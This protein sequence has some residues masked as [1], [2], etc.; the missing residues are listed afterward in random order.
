MTKTNMQKVRK[1]QTL[2]QVTKFEVW[3]HPP[4]EDNVIHQAL[5]F[6]ES[7][8]QEWLLS[9]ENAGISQ[10]IPERELSGLSFLLKEGLKDYQEPT[11]EAIYEADSWAPY[12]TRLPGVRTKD[13]SDSKVYE[14]NIPWPEEKSII[15]GQETFNQM[16]LYQVGGEWFLKFPSGPKTLH[17]E[18]NALPM[19]SKMVTKVLKHVNKN[20]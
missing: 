6:T 12:A 7:S 14:V 4:F 17:L 19:L 1:K 18:Y 10:M 13:V 5:M 16:R 11:D 15:V 2:Y 8:D 20:S 9:V 3:V